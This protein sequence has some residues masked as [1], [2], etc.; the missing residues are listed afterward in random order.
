MVSIP[1]ARFRL[2]RAHFHRHG[3]ID[4]IADQPDVAQVG[5][6]VAEQVDALADAI[7][8]LER[9]ASCVTAGIGQ[10]RDQAVAD[11]IAHGGEDNRDR[12]GSFLRGD[13]LR[14][15]GG[16]DEIDRPTDKL[17][18]DFARARH[19]ALGEPRIN[20]NVAALRPTEIGKPL[21]EGSDARPIDR[22]AIGAD[23]AD[24]RRLAG[25]LRMDGKRQRD[26]SQ[27]PRGKGPPFHVASPS[28]REPLH[29]LHT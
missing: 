18:R 22:L 14:V 24:D 3:R 19:H 12:V 13:D 23:I 8:E 6:E 27:E 28:P 4:E 26:S 17:G 15:A 2:C 29:R 9:Q 21:H 11:G 25:A 5:Q 10:A 1:S 7:G 16:E 20:G